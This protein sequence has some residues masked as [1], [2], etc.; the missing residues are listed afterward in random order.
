MDLLTD[1]QVWLSFLSLSLLEVVLGIDNLIFLSIITQRL[2]PTVQRRAQTIGLIGALAM[3]IAL[4]F[5]ISWI[6]SLQ[7]P[8]V[9]ILGQAIS[10]RDVILLLGGLFLLYK[11]VTEIHESVEGG[12]LK[13]GE[14]RK[15]VSF[16]GA[17]VQIML[18]DL[19]FSLDS[20]ITAV[21]MVEHIEVMIASVCLAIGVMMFAAQPVSAFIKRHPTVKMLALSFLLLVGVAL[22]AD[23]M[24]FHIPRGY[25][26]FA[27]GFSVL[28]EM[29][30]LAARKNR[31]KLADEPGA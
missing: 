1:P 11:G 20:V 22:V 27:I 19:V 4:L 8:F 28:V 24:H 30:N 7:D 18:L 13:G 17:I 3:R 29:L 16:G 2:P 9:T 14:S 23:G 5:A 10:W 25:L 21:G 31:S 26:Y 15:A 12:G 6:I